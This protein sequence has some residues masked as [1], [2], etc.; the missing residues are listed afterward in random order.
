MLKAVTATLVK[1]LRKTDVVARVGGDEF[2]VFLPATDNEAVQVVMQKVREELCQLAK[3]NNWPISF[4]VGVV[5][6]NCGSCEFSEVM[7]KADGLMYEVKKAGKDNIRFG[8]LNDG[9]I[10]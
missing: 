5:T 3:Q 1:H 8:I 9:D 10:D 6:S 4:S 7:S 2:T